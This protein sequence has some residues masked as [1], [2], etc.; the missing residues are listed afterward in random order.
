MPAVAKF[1]VYDSSVRSASGS[2]WQWRHRD[3]QT[4]LLDLLYYNVISPQTEGMAADAPDAV[5]ASI[6]DEWC[7][8]YRIYNAG[9]DSFGRPGRFLIAASLLR[10]ADIVGTDSIVVLALEFFRAVALAAEQSTPMA[11]PAS[12]EASMDA[13]IE[14]S[15]SAE[16]DSY[17][18]EASIQLRGQDAVRTAVIACSRLA[19]PA[20]WRLDLQESADGQNLDGQLLISRGH[21]PLP[22]SCSP[23]P[24]ALL[25]QAPA[26]DRNSRPRLF[27]LTITAAIILIISAASALTIAWYLPTRPEIR[28]RPMAPDAHRRHQGDEL[29]PERTERGDPR[30]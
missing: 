13:N 22:D 20:R 2:H 7:C 1:A 11:A 4:L 14:P 27:R 10:R 16:A 3:L 29:S 9:R 28:R 6:D 18:G 12:L 25:A 21:E 26:A 24:E 30:M 23:A 19:P 17:F 5:F 8:W 15:G